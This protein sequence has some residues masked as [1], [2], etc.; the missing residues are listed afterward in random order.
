LRIL[1][2]VSIYFVLIILLRISGKRTL[3]DMNIFDFVVTVAIGTTLSSTII[4]KDV[5]V[6]DGL[7]ALLSLVLLQYIIAFIAVRSN[8]LQKMIKSRPTILFFKG[9][10]L[11]AA[12]RKERVSREEIL[13]AMR[14]QGVSIEEQV[15][16]VILETNGNVSVIKKS[17]NKG[18]STFANL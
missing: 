8:H 2:S 16:A 4:S 6:V 7:L 17:E 5:A 15:E 3:S 14:S 1:I 18:T 12:M 10:Y 11:F 9:K 13:Q